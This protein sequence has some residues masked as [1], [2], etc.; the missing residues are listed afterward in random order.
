MRSHLHGPGP[1]DAVGVDKVAHKG[2][3]GDAAVLDLGV[4]EETDGR[5]VAGAPELGLGEVQRVVELHQ[6]VQGGGEGLEVGL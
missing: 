1:L 4:A 5:L 3:H 2:K 6:G